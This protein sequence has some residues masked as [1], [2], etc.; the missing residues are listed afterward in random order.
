MRLG[1]HPVLRIN[2]GG[3]FRPDPQATSRPLTSFA[4]QPGTRWRGT[5]T[6]FKRPQQGLRCTL[7]AY[8]E[9]GYSAPWPLLTDLPP[10]A[11]EASWYGLRAWIEQQF[12]CSKRAGWQR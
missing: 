2:T 5:G 11:G 8:W 1:W 12:K 4:P 7:L 3:T 9:A 10:E 6:A